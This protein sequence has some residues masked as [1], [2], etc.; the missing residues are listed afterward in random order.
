MIPKR[1]ARRAGQ[2]LFRDELHAGP[3]VRLDRQDFNTQLGEWLRRA[4]NR[5][6]ATL[7]CRPNERIVEDRAAMMTLPPVLPDPAWR[8]DEAAAAGI[9][10]CGSTPATTRCTH[11]PSAVGSRCAWTSTR[12]SSPAPAPRSPATSAVVGEA[13]HH[14]RPSPRRSPARSCAPSRPPWPTSSTTTSRC[15]TSS[16]YDRATGAA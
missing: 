13:P 14:H 6:H 4:N 7:R 5:M 15:A 2:R 9:I 8:R 16:V 1:R 11:G 12:S 3:P 10:G